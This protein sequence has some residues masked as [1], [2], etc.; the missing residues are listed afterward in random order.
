M[1]SRAT[2]KAGRDDRRAGG[3]Q[4]GD[5][6][7]LRAHDAFERPDLLEVHGSDV[8]DHADL[9]PR[10]RAE[11]G[12][13]A[14]A[15][16]RQLEDADLG[17]RLEPAERERHADL[18]VVAPLRRDRSRLLRR[19][20]RARMSFVDVLPI[21][22]VIATKRALLRSRTAPRERGERRERLVGDER[23]RRAA[24]ERVLRYVG[25]VA[26]RDEEV[27]LLDPARVDLDAGDLVRP[28]GA[29]PA[30]PGP[31]PRHV[32]RERDH[33]GCSARNTLARD[34]AVVEGMRHARD[35]LPLLV[36]LAGDQHDVSFAR[37]T[38]SPLRSPRAGRARPRAR[39]RRR[40][41]SSMIAS[42]SSLRGLSEVTIATSASS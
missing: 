19:R 11:L 21:E 7:A 37:R 5:Q 15:A 16:H 26:E 38:R 3:R 34:L 35:L 36:A 13:L 29:L 33:A 8:R 12:D 6:L 20:S 30:V 1:S 40:A 23:R 25:A 17:V 39:A 41:I 28:H 4:R 2:A 10:E 32:Q 27:A 42:G 24:R 18:V 31:G 14:E 9:R 22:P